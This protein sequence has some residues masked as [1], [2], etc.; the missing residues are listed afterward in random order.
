MAAMARQLMLMEEPILPVED[1]M[2]HLEDRSISRRK[3]ELRLQLDSLDRESDKDAYSHTL[4]KLIRLLERSPSRSG[5][6]K[7]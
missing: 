1:V 4:E 6:E 5:E 3:A 2:A 7:V